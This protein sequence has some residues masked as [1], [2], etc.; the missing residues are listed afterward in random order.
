LTEGAFSDPVGRGKWDVA[1][2]RS[3][4]AGLN[5]GEDEALVRSIIDLRTTS[6]WK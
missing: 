2:D 5:E 1:I 3:F 4:I 6:S